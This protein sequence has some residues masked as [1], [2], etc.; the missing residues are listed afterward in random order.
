VS[1]RGTGDG[2]K[3]KEDEADSGFHASTPFFHI[4]LPIFA[5]FKLQGDRLTPVQSSRVQ[6][7]MFNVQRPTL[8]CSSRSRRSNG[9]ILRASGQAKLTTERNLSASLGSK[10]FRSK[11]QE[12]A[13]S[14]SKGSTFKV[15][16]KEAGKE[17]SEPFLLGFQTS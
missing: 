4:Y 15:F 14:V 12:P 13:L 2:Q 9:S 1:V 10:S 7:S 17:G 8:S 11:V 6:G 5:D 3:D 16:L